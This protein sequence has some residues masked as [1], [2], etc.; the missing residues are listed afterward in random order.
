MATSG[1]IRSTKTYIWYTAD[2]L[3]TGATSTVF[4]GRHKKT[5]DLVAVKAFNNISFLRPH[6]V[7]QREFDVL[8]KLNHPNI[9]KLYNIEDDQITK[10]PVIIMELCTGGSLYHM[11]DEPENCY[12]VSE[13]EFKNVLKD[14]CE[15][16]K[17]L[18][19]QGVVHRDIKPGNIMRVLAEDGTYMYKLADFGAAREL[20]DEENF[21]SL[22]GTEEYLHPDLYE[23][24]VLRQP[25]RRAFT[26][27]IDLWSIGVTFF[28]VATGVLPFR[29]HGGR[30][31]RETM[32][33]I[34][35]KK[36]SGVISGVQRESSNGPIEWSNELPKTCR[37]SQGLRTRVT[38][39]LQ[40]LLEC[41]PEHMWTFEEFFDC[42]R[43]ILDMRVIDVFSV[44]TSQLLKVYID[45]KLT[46]AEFQEDIAQQTS[47]RASSQS[48]Y[49]DNE[50]F[51]PESSVKCESFPATS[52][53]QPLLL[54]DKGAAEFPRPVPPAQPKLPRVTTQYSLDNDVPVAKMCSAVLFF[55]LQILMSVVLMQR[56]FGDAVKMLITVL[57]NQLQ[58]LRQHVVE[59]K[60]SVVGIQHCLNGM[61]HSIPIDL[62]HTMSIHGDDAVKA[63]C[64]SMKKVWE[65]TNSLKSRSADLMTEYL[66]TEGN[67]KGLFDDIIKENTLTKSWDGVI[68]DFGLKSCEKCIGKFGVLKDD[69]RKIYSQFKRD[70]QAKTLSYNEEQ[71]HKMDK[72]KLGV[73]ST[74]AMSL[75]QSHCEER[76]RSLH[77][78]LSVWYRV[79][80][81]P[82]L[83]HYIKV[84]VKKDGDHSIRHS[85][86]GIGKILGVK[87][88]QAMSLYQSHCEERWRSLHKALSVWYRPLCDYR[89][90]VA[91]VDTQL[92]RLIDAYQRLEIQVQEMDATVQRRV[93]E[94]NRAL[95]VELTKPKPELPIIVPQL[96]REPP[97]T[98]VM[99]NTMEETSKLLA[100]LPLD[101][102]GMVIVPK[103]VKD[104]LQAW[105]KDVDRVAQELRDSKELMSE[106]SRI[107]M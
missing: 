106:L 104:C 24:A 19:D 100:S 30:K 36:A 27:R 43:N 34:T 90:R 105:E 96:P 49:W 20:H 82:K 31:N 93:S 107:S 80:K 4:K 40:G 94:F 65:E 59:L 60:A 22:Y 67:L 77:K 37:L 68:S 103:E 44:S 78:A 54:L 84:I 12:G 81:V 2:V 76:W 26:A 42:A 69:V 13:Q 5:G 58:Q 35:T 48:I 38:K 97:V 53:E 14:V 62:V 7:Q 17:H 33:F 29:P 55:N 101:S 45:P 32:F 15:G 98:C 72:E 18:R 41:N 86:Y 79:L 11:L 92:S 85:V 64:N 83:C 52:E 74:Q 39:L 88:T 47:I 16:M 25:I 87:S 56:L 57:R 63:L 6:A 66:L 91:S 75:Y 10:Q 89:T 8:L 50:H 102:N 21:M 95:H 46:L 1:Q 99:S 23:R 9:V 3:G 73:K 51:I 28:H 61:A 71:I 70:K